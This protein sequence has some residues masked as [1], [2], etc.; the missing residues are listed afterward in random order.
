MSSRWRIVDL[1]DYSGVIATNTGRLVVGPTEVPLSDVSCVLIGVGTRISG[2]VLELCSRFDVPILTCDWRGVPFSCSYG[3]SDNSRVGARH[4]AQ[5]ELSSPRKKNAWMRLVK[6]KISG[7]AANLPRTPPPGAFSKPTLQRYVRVT[8]TTSKP[9]RPAPI[10]PPCSMTPRF[11]EA[12][13]V[14]AEMIFST[15]ATPC[16]GERSSGASTLLA[17]R[18][19]WAYGTATAPMFSPSPMT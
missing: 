15:M 8:P 14:V 17:S 2:A 13:T 1:V 9:E 5:S 19:H 10:G 4:R 7:Q 3:W 16:Y 6:A 11:R 18:P 12:V